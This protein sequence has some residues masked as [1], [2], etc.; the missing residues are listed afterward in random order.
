MPFTCARDFGRVSH[1][2]ALVM[3]QIGS[4]QTHSVQGRGA[5]VFL[6]YFHQ[7]LVW[8]KVHK[9]LGSEKGWLRVSRAS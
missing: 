5:P 7:L 3:S 6:I 4:F 2:R 9:K 8:L 1:L